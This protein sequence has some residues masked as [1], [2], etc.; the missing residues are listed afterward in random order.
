M[1][2]YFEGM[3]GELVRAD[4]CEEVFCFKVKVQPKIL[5]GQVIGTYKPF[6]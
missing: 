1:N 6:F 3:I 4:A 5:L 2:M